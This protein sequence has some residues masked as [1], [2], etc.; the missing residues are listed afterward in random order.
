MSSDA[1]ATPSLSPSLLVVD[2][3]AAI[4]DYVAAVGTATGCETSVCTQPL[5][6]DKHLVNMPDIIVLDLSMPGADG[7]SVIRDLA[8]AGCTSLLILMSGVD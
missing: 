4:A 3:E 5:S 8:S 7:I 1:G 6:L 2:D